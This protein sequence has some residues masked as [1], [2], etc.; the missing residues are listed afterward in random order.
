MPTPLWGQ[1]TLQGNGPPRVN[2]ATQADS[3]LWLHHFSRREA[4]TFAT[5]EKKAH[6]SKHLLFTDS[7]W[8]CPMSPGL[9]D[10]SEPGTCCLPSGRRAEKHVFLLLR[11]KGSLCMFPLAVSSGRTRFPLSLACAHS[12]TMPC[13]RRRPQPICAMR[14]KCMVTSPCRQSS[15][16]SQLE[17]LTGH[18]NT[19]LSGALVMLYVVQ[20]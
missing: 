4:L 16:P 6:E 19:C 8:Q 1:A 15:G 18:L 11:T 3:I 5:T 2:S 7:A 12:S 13:A 20:I 14:D 17:P 10:R 9:R